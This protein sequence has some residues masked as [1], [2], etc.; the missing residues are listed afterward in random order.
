[1][2][3]IT[4]KIEEAKEKAAEA[5]ENNVPGGEAVVAAAEAATTEPVADSGF[6]KGGNWKTSLLGAGCECGALIDFTFCY[7][8]MMSR[9]CEAVEGNPNS[10]GLVC[11]ILSS[12]SYPPPIMNLVACGLRGEVR[13]NWNIE[14]GGCCQ[15]ILAAFICPLCS[16]AQCWKEL[17]ERRCS[18]GGVCCASSMV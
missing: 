10:C 15:D 11:C 14:D 12:I 18:P 6:I 8:C 7:P 16:N 9:T 2:S 4:D 3:G 5:V 1:M 17:G 13:S